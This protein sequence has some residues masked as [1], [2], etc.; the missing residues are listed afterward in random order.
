[1]SLILQVLNGTTRT[2]CLTITP[3]AAGMRT[4]MT[5]TPHPTPVSLATITALAAPARLPPPSTGACINGAKRVDVT[6]YSIVSV[7][8]DCIPLI[9]Y[10]CQCMWSGRGLRSSDLWYSHD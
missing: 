1:M 5:A 10:M 3:R 4:R 8:V 6:Y 7:V 2:S 9:V